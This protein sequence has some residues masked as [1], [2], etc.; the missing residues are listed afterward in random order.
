MNIANL[1]KEKDF[2][3]T[4]TLGTMAASNLTIYNPKTGV[5]AWLVHWMT[6]FGLLYPKNFKIDQN[7]MNAS[8]KM[9][10]EFHYLLWSLR[11]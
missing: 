10:S 1:K 5:H 2:T 11:L 3:K 7:L 8:L 4:P 9:G 6:N